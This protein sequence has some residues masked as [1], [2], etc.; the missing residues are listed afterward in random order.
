[1][2]YS[3]P[4]RMAS[5][6]TIRQ[7]ASE[8]YYHV[9]NRGVAKSEIFRDSGDY[10][11]FLY[12][13]Q[14][15][16]GQ[17]QICS[18][19]RKQFKNFYDKITLVSYCLMP[20]HFHL[21]VFQVHDQALE[22]LMRCLMTSYSMYFN[23]RYNRVGPVF[24]GRYKAATI[25][26][27]MYLEHISR[28]IHLNP[29]DIGEDYKT[30]EYSS[31]RDYVDENVKPWLQVERGAAGI[32]PNQYAEFVADYESYHNELNNLKHSLADA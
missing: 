29:M 14:R 6:N 17:D 32:T 19:S 15:Y 8:T 11:Y 9:Y 26:N 5:R 24:Q 27:D 4:A 31:Y 10:T 21:Q 13:L 3:Y 12:L 2:R 18:P 23:K 28:Y 7:S 1:M 25:D 30:Y 22:E 16:L 20:N